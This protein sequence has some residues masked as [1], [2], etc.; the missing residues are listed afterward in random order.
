MPDSEVRFGAGLPSGPDGEQGWNARFGASLRLQEGRLG[1]RVSYARNEL[2]GYTDN[3][4]DGRDDINGGSQTGARAAL[5]WDGDAIDMKL[6]A[7]HQG[8]DSDNSALVSLDPA[9]GD[10]MFD[11][12]TGQAWQPQPFPTALSLYRPEAH[13]YEIKSQM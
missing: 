10:P 9:T 2:P 12:I 6:A 1:L 5:V 13:T 7:L 8:I 4:V 3:A 11:D